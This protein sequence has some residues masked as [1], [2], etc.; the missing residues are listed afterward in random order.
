MKRKEF[1]DQF[2]LVK[3][4]LECLLYVA[5]EFGIMFQPFAIQSESEKVFKLPGWGHRNVNE[6]V[7]VLIVG[8]GL[9][10]QLFDNIDK[11]TQLIK[12]KISSF[13][14]G[15]DDLKYEMPTH[16][17][18]FVKNKL[19]EWIKTP[20]RRTQWNPRETTLL[21]DVIS[22]QQILDPRVW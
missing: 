21:K 18:S 11:P 9:V 3:K 4:I 22:F 17:H 8:E 10:C 16:L 13:L 1:S 14:T 12:D 15:D 20:L 7:N 5:N 19:S 2:L 6:T